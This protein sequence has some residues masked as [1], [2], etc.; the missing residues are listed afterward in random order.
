MTSRRSRA[1]P[2]RVQGRNTGAARFKS[3]ITTK[4]T[5]DERR[6]AIH[7][8]GDARRGDVY[9]TD[10]E[11]APPKE[12]GARDPSY[13]SS[14]R[15]LERIAELYGRGVSQLEISNELDLSPG[16]IGQLIRK[17]GIVKGGKK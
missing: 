12:S 9:R 10:V 5:D 1:A 11:F 3:A 16:Y 13:G 8:L 4:R 14:L 6:A 17:Y 15:W 2:G 7:E